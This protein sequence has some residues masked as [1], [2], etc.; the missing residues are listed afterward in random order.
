MPD[1]PVITPAGVSRILSKV[2]SAGAMLSFKP[3]ASIQ[4]S[5][6]IG[7]AAG[8][9]RLQWEWQDTQTLTEQQRRFVCR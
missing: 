7:M 6:P 5:W 8:E 1:A 2:R 4:S 3:A 9:R